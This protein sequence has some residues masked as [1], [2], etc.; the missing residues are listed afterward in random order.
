[1]ALTKAHARMI[2]GAAVN[3]VDFGAV[4]DGV[5]DDTAAIQAAIDFANGE[6][7]IHIPSGT[8]LSGALT[9]PPK[10]FYLEGEIPPEN[11]DQSSQPTII[12][13]NSAGITLFS[14]D[15]T[16]SP[17]VIANPTWKFV[18]LEGAS[19][20]DATTKLIYID[21]AVAP[22]CY[23]M[24]LDN[25][26]LINC[27]FGV[28]AVDAFNG[29]FRHTHVFNCATA[30][31]YGHD[32]PSNVYENPRVGTVPSSSNTSITSI[33]KANPAVVTSTSHN[34]T[35]GGLVYIVASGMTEVNRRIF[36]AENVTTSTFELKG[37]DST[38][39][40]TFTSGNCRKT[41]VGCWSL[42]PNDLVLNSD[43]SAE[44]SGVGSVMWIVGES[45]GLNLS[46]STTTSHSDFVSCHFEGTQGAFIWVT[47]G[48]S[49]Q[50]DSCHFVTSTNPLPRGI[51]FE[52]V[53]DLISMTSPWFTTKVSGSYT[54]EI[55]VNSAAKGQGKIIIKPKGVNDV[56]TTSGGHTGLFYFDVGSYGVIA[57][58][59]ADQ[60]IPT[61][62]ETKLILGTEINDTDN[63][64]DATTG[65][66]TPLVPGFYTAS[67]NLFYETAVDGKVYDVRLKIDSVEKQRV[68]VHAAGTSGLSA[69][70]SFSEEYIQGDETV[71]FFVFHNSGSDINVDA[72]FKTT[73][74]FFKK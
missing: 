11:L 50:L 48:S 51:Y 40:G 42:G 20:S 41:A 19:S 67:G 60:A 4:G 5:T 16:G 68:R 24:T 18:R 53:N 49:C 65:D 37:V 21:E 38:S 58:E 61:G 27:D 31:L 22:A 47:S 14:P 59:S 69:P 23:G 70:I 44:S 63:I 15:Y 8:Y 30:G 36:V 45:T 28:H 7:K 9:F 71:E 29:K 33:T 32:G 25:V 74:S 62:T 56:P 54:T 64:H 17:S 57:A 3:V 34:V 2:E 35:E 26:G 1:M 66:I 72:G 6:R 10:G 12:R 13:A 43:T 52:Y 73:I 55:E 46:G 39:F